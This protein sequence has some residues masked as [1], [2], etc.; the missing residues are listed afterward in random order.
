M[1]SALAEVMGTV[2]CFEPALTP[3]N[4]RLEVRIL[5]GIFHTNASV[6]HA[7]FYDCPVN[8]VEDGFVRSY[9]VSELVDLEPCKACFVNTGRLLTTISD[10]LL[11]VAAVALEQLRMIDN[12]IDPLVV[13]SKVTTSSEFVELVCEYHRYLDILTEELAEN[14]YSV[15]PKYIAVIDS[16]S[17]RMSQ[18]FENLH[19][20][21]VGQDHFKTL[22]CEHARIMYGIDSDHSLVSVAVESS[23]A[24]P[25]M[26]ASGVEDDDRVHADFE[27]ALFVAFAKNSDYRREVKTLPRWVVEVFRKINHERVVSEDLP[28]ADSTLLDTANRLWSRESGDVLH[29]FTNA[30]NAARKLLA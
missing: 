27:S 14:Y 2:R 9:S 15:D 13:R 21:T 22:L 8:G 4:L 26:Y 5:D 23:R 25:G 30:Y 24:Y 11:R 19:Q 18:R 20:L 7:H 16:E 12:D 28:S 29:D 10:E 6:Y 17:N 1:N 3:E